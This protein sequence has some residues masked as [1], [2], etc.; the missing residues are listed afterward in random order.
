M[1]KKGLGL[2]ALMT[3]AMLSYQ[4]SVRAM[5]P[6]VSDPGGIV[7]GDLEE[8]PSNNVFVYPDVF[9]LQASVTDDNTP[10]A[11]IIW[12]YTGSG[13]YTLNGVAPNGGDPVNPAPAVQIQAN[14][15]DNIPAMG[16]DALADTFTFRNETL[17]PLAGGPAYPDPA[18]GPGILAAETQTIT[19]IASDGATVGF[20]TVTVYTDDDGPDAISGGGLVPV[21][22][23]D[24]TPPNG[25]QGWTGSVLSGGSTTGTASGLCMYAPLTGNNGAA[26]LAPGGVNPPGY[27]TLVDKAVYRIRLSMIT[28]QTAANAIPFWDFG[29]NNF[30][31]DYNTVTAGNQPQGNNY[32]GLFWNLDVSGGAAGIG[33]FRDD[34][35]FWA[36]PN[37]VITQQWRGIVDPVASAFD[38]IVDALNDMNLLVRVL[39]GNTAIGAN[40]DSGTICIQRIQVHRTDVDTLSKTVLKGD[41]I[42]NAVHA[43]APDVFGNPGTG[44]SAVI[45]DANNVAN[46]SLAPNASNNPNGARKQLIFYDQTLVPNFDQ[47]LYPLVWTNDLVYMLETDVRSNVNGGNPPEGTDPLDAI[48]LDFITPNNEIGGQH[49]TSRG[50]NVPL[51]MYRA[52]SPRLAQTTGG[53]TQTYVGFV[54]AGKASVAGNVDKHR[55]SAHGD[56]F[57]TGLTVGTATDGLDPFTI[58]TQIIYSV[59]P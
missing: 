2:V 39:D 48:F 26:W 57:N 1:I 8:G 29:Y 45:V 40:A 3:V 16:Q 14:D 33:R 56:F 37:S 28:D 32:G 17:S 9:S 18:G 20:R 49:F 59:T 38:P 51:G 5:A 31:Q 58:E 42:Q 47:A 22:D 19:L 53:T 34:F 23:T 30:Y 27:I 35:D 54:A 24:F 25:P 50:R 7:I 44:S 43:I 52:P 13:K 10:A 55:I 46:I 11:S 15:L 36:T 4:T 21:I 41:P 12:S 6:V